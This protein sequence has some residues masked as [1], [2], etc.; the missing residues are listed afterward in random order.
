MTQ[1]DL[2]EALRSQGVSDIEGVA[3]VRLER[4]GRVSVVETRPEPRVLEVQV[5]E[6][7]QTI[8]IQVSSG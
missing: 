2:E 7:V 5:A 3:E 6:G 4:S 8:R 1:G